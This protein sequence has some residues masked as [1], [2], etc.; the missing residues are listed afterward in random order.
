M[1]SQGKTSDAL[2]KLMDLQASE[3]CLV[4]TES[5]L[6]SSN[7]CIT[8]EEVEESIPHNLIQFNDILKVRPG[9]KVPAD[10]VVVH[11]SSYVDEAMVTGRILRGLYY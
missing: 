10:G 6:E 4:K 3:A 5:G 8:G 9:C 11:G 7:V 1:T 2:Y